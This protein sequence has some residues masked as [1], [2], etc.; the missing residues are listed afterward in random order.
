MR[1]TQLEKAREIYKLYLEKA[2]DDTVYQEDEISIALDNSNNWNKWGAHYIRSLMGSHQHRECI[3]FKDPSVQGYQNGK[4][5]AWKTLR[6]AAHDTYKDLP[7]PEP[8][9]S[10]TSLRSLPGWKWERYSSSTTPCYIGYVQ[11]SGQWLSS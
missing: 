6:D 10:D 1:S 3:N 5:D 2:G 9:C 7:A 4:E 8:T 11:S